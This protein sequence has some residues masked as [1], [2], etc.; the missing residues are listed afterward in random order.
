MR[1]NPLLSCLIAMFA[2][3]SVGSSLAGAEEPVDGKRD[4]AAVEFF[5]SKIRPVLI[6]QCYRCHSNETGNA[7]GGLRLDTRQLTLI[8]GD[9]GPAVEPGNLE[10]SRLWAAINYEDFEMPPKTPLPDHVI[11]DFRVWIEGGAVDPR[12]TKIVSIA[13]TMTPEAIAESKKSFWA[14]QKPV[15]P[16]TADGEEG[17]TLSIDYFIMER[18]ESSGLTPCDTADPSALLK[19]LTYD[20]TGLAPTAKQREMFEALWDQDPT[21]AVARAADHLMD[22]PQFGERWGRHWLDV[23]RFSESTGGTVNMTYPHAWRYRDYVI[24]SFNQDKPYDEFVQ[25]QIA[26][27]LIPAKDDG[28]WSEHLIATTFLAIGT[29]NVNERNPVQFEA[30]LVD[31]Q[32]DVTTRVFL[33]QSVACA[34]CHDHKF[35]PIPQTDYYAMAGIFASTKTYFGNPPSSY[36]QVKTAQVR[37]TSSLILLPVD[38]PNP[39][40]PRY[41]KSELTQLQEQIQDLQ[42]ELAAINPR[43]QKLMMEDQGKAKQQVNLQ[44]QRRR[45]EADISRLSVK[46]AIVDDEGQPR[47]YCMGVQDR[48]TL[49]N[50]RVLV[51]GE[52]DSPGQRVPRGVPQVLCDTPLEIPQSVSGRLQLARWIG[53]DSNPVAARVM[54]N[55]VWGTLLGQG[56]V[57]TTENFGSSGIAPSHPELLD[58]LALEFVDSGWSV[59]SLIRK[60]VT[61]QTYQMGS[62]YEEANFHQDPENRLLWRFTPR[63]LDAEAIRDSML[64]ISG[65]LDRA[66]PR[67]SEVAK[68][69]FVPIRDGRFFGDPKRQRDQMRQM[70]RKM[71][72]QKRRSRLDRD[73]VRRRSRNPLQME[74]A[75]IRSVYLPVVRENVPRSL[76]VFDFANPNLVIGVRESSITANQALYLMNNPFVIDQARALAAGIKSKSETRSRQVK[77]SFDHVL[78][79]Q[80]TNSE[81]MSAIRYLEKA[82]LAA[83]CQGLFASAE[84]RFLD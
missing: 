31:E 62:H 79:R 81:R 78:G 14:Y 54:V 18:L 33:G 36:A 57:T 69:G 74:E 59:K 52:I 50:A 51:R 2:C 67:G 42:Q 48:Q 72:Q 1:R 34:R 16:K 28:Q 55:R 9:N 10:E 65:N 5:E 60:I 26:G 77:A 25:E 6:K 35:D 58:Y 76:E 15:R 32:I 41:A 27:D 47:A 7:K 24:D 17:S 84:F 49:V 56:I 39:F 22:Q 19:R 83:V 73:R 45:L 43:R 68:A 66:R 13:S 80:P 53:S 38:D 71:S 61:S 70:V 29:K 12:D 37:R 44:R 64:Q 75:T 40:D 20:L 63:R 11:E 3:V 46:L 30:D 21:M 4:P 23:V 8:G 82:N